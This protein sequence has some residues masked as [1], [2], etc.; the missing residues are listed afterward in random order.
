[1]TEEA[2]KSGENT[3]YEATFCFDNVFVK[4]DILHR[5][6]SGWEIYEVKSATECKKVHLSDI[7]VQQYV[8]T[9]SGVTIVRA[10]LIHINNRYVRQGDI[11]V[12]KLFTILDVT[13]KVLVREADVPCELM[14]MRK[15]LGENMPVPD[16]GPHCE[17]PY[18]CDFKGHCWS[19]TTLIPC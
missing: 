3:I 14:A 18:P 19:H 15:P 8:V 6:E 13:D 9:G 1:M 10:C 5:V 2:L 12:E 17:N 4:V 11:E 7:A 16:V